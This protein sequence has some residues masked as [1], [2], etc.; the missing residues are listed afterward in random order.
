MLVPPKWRDWLERRLAGLGPPQ[1][2]VQAAVSS[3]TKVRRSE[4]L[5]HGMCAEGWTRVA[6]VPVTTVEGDTSAEQATPAALEEQ[7]GSAIREQGRGD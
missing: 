6:A 5:K 2:Q 3:A 1:S 4:R 7:V